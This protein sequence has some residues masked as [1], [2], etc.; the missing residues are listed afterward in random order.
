[1]NPSKA[2]KLFKLMKSYGVSH[3]KSLEVEIRIDL[4]GPA[5]LKPESSIPTSVEKIPEPQAIPPVEVEIPHHVNEVA[6]LLKLNDSDLVDK[7]FPDYS[8]MPP[9]GDE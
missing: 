9:K 8:Q 2:E 7:L 5:Q 3:F 1:M 4:G 6:N